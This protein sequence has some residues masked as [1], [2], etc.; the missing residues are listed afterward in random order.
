MLQLM[1]K[2]QKKQ[3]LAKP[4]RGQWTPCSSR[5]RILIIKQGLTYTQIAEH[6]L[7]DGIPCSEFNVAN[8]VRGF[9]KRPDIRAGIAKMLK[10]QVE[11]LWPQRMAS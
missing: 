1:Q 10:V 11:Q 3:K 9:T 5:A 4:Q 7:S 6:L 8:V 2:S